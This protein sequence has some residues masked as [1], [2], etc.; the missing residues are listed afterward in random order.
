MILIAFGFAACGTPKSSDERKI[1]VVSIAPL[2]YIVEQIADTTVRVEVLVPE[3]TSPETYEPTIKQIHSL[4]NASAYLAVGLIDFEHELEGRIKE[5]APNAKYLNVSQ[6][7][8][9][10]EGECVHG[11]HNHSH[12]TDPHIW[13]SPKLV[14]QISVKVAELL[15]AQNPDSEQLYVDNLTK[16]TTLIDSLDVE[17]AS[18]LSNAPRVFAIA[19]P[20]LTYFANDY[21]LTQIPVEIE[22]KEP[23]A[24]SL[25]QTIEQV[26]KAKVATIIYSKQASD[27]AAKTLAREVG[28]SLVEFDPLS[29]DW[30][31]NLRY[32][33]K[34]IANGA[35]QN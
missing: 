17:L 5:I 12:G 16:F 6:D 25:R 23:S 7:L 3:T 15:I 4:S 18:I 20:S 9:L 13:L 22:G 34:E 1:V 2:G 27:Q 21:G 14:R 28:A 19:H 24:N 29:A 8:Q 32:I 26:R 10:L 11:D 35:G 33:S 30:A 31:N